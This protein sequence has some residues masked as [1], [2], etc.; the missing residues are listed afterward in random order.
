MKAFGAQFSTTYHVF[1][2][3]RGRYRYGSEWDVLAERGFAKNF[4][5]GVKYADYRA[6]DNL[7]NVARNT[8]GEQAFDLT[9][10]WVYV[11]YRF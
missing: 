11:Q 5:G 10:F 1:H 3:D 7:D 2:S 8:I 4:L 9:K 6:D